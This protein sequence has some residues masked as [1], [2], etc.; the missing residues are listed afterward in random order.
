MEL[1]NLNG[2]DPIRWL[3]LVEKFFEIHDVNPKLK[4]ELAFIR[5]EG[6]IIH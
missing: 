1:L 4:V 5:I 6:L 2:N 3:A